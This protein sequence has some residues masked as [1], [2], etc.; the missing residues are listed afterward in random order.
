MAALSDW[1]DFPGSP[2][3]LPVAHWVLSFSHNRSVPV[4][5][6]VLVASQEIPLLRATGESLYSLISRDVWIMLMTDLQRFGLLTVALMRDEQV[7]GI[8][9]R[10]LFPWETHWPSLAAP[11]W[12]LPG[13]Y[14]DRALPTFTFDWRHFLVSRLL[15]SHSC[16]ALPPA[17]NVVLEH[18]FGT[19]TWEP[20]IFYTQI[21]EMSRQLLMWHSRLALIKFSDARGT[22]TSCGYTRT[23]ITTLQL[24]MGYAQGVFPDWALE[25]SYYPPEY[26]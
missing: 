19:A 18:H 12:E 25:C 24:C 7:P 1:I 23:A 21:S 9:S 22:H 4:F 3:A 5:N 16:S 8:Q 15:L 6:L 20:R 2:Y 26:W 11:V 17:L 14:L 10:F 13:A